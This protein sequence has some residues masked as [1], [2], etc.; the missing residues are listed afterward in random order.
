MRSRQ[1]LIPIDEIIEEEFFHL[2][3]IIFQSLKDEVFDEKYEFIYFIFSLYLLYLKIVVG[4]EQK[5]GGRSK[6]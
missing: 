2:E 5:G 1:K 3:K 6:K 4:I